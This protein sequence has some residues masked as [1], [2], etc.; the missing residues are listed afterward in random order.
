MLHQLQRLKQACKLL[1][2][3]KLILQL[4]RLEHL[5][6]APQIPPLMRLHISQQVQQH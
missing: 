4:Q 1:Q 2:Q 6:A 5:L 3:L